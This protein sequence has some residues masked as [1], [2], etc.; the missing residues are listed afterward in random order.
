LLE[1]TKV[2]GKVIFKTGELLKH[3]KRLVAS[4]S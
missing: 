3:E 1:G 2:D 4:N